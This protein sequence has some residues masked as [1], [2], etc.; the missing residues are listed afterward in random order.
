MTTLSET[1][2]TAQ[3]LEGLDLYSDASLTD[4]FPIYDRLRSIG[5]AVWLPAHSVWA[6]TGYAAA[7]A[8]LLNHR[9]FISGQGIGLTPA[10]NEATRGA[11]LA[12]DPPEHGHLRAVLNERLSP[13]GI[14][15]MAPMVEA[16]AATLV[17]AVVDAGSFD[18]VRDFARVFPLSIVGEL[19]GV[20]DEI[21][22]K[23]LSWADSM[24]NTFGPPNERTFR[25][26]PQLMEMGAFLQSVTIDS[27]KPGSFGAA[28]YQ[29]GARGTLRPDQCAVLL[30][31]YLGAGLDTT[32][33]SISAALQLFAENP[34]Q[35]DRLRQ[36]P[37]LI[38]QAYDEV[39]RVASPVLGFTRVA[40][41]DVEIGGQRIAEGDRVLL[42]NAAA[43]RDPRKYADPN[44]FDITRAPSDHL[45]FGMGRHHCAG[46]LL[47]RLEAEALLKALVPKVRRFS[48][49]EP[50]RHLNNVIRGLESLPIEVSV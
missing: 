17:A 22:A 44:R 15:E 14:K 9:A 42:L 28:I 26:L 47:A 31:A 18:G 35:W 13:S 30:G 19:I 38:P 50:V 32:I 1:V 45:A 20:S 37:D 23:A 34:D 2:S 11:I 36:K 27:L 6:V 29:A 40:S 46:Q 16:Q 39:L 10:A 33:N 5:E 7:K 43:N 41:A 25:S 49:G 48:A 12:S 4:P 21:N 24:F 3:W 8:A